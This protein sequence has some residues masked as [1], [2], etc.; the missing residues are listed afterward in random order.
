[1]TG[2]NRSSGRS[3]RAKKVSRGFLRLKKLTGAAG[4]D[5]LTARRNELPRL[6]GGEATVRHSRRWCVFIGAAGVLGKGEVADR[7]RP[8]G[9]WP[10]DVAVRAVN[11]SITDR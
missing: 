11:G 2:N 1:M 10:V 9:R 5:D 3:G 8:R 4:W 7:G 6:V